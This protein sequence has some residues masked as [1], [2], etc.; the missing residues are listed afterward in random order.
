MAAKQK[1]GLAAAIQAAQGKEGFEGSLPPEFGH[2]IS[3][4]EHSPPPVSAHASIK[5]QN[6]AAHAS[7][8]EDSVTAQAYVSTSQ[9]TAQAIIKN[10]QVTAHAMFNNSRVTA[11][12]SI[13]NNQL[14]ARAYVSDPSDPSGGK[15][16][17][18]KVEKPNRKSSCAQKEKKSAKDV[19]SAIPKDTSLSLDPKALDASVLTS[20]MRA[21][22]SSQP[23][24]NIDNAPSP[25]TPVAPP[26]APMPS[27]RSSPAAR[28]VSTLATASPPA[29][30]T[31]LAPAPTQSHT[32]LPSSPQQISPPPSVSAALPLNMPSAHSSSAQENIPSPGQIIPSITTTPELPQN[33][34]VM[35]S[36]I[37]PSAKWPT[38]T[39]FLAQGVTGTENTPS[40]QTNWFQ[41][42]QLELN[43][44]NNNNKLQVGSNNPSDYP[45][46]KERLMGSFFANTAA[47]V[48]E[49]PRPQTTVGMV[50]RPN[51][52]PATQ[53]GP[54]PPPYPGTTDPQP[55]PTPPSY[56]PKSPNLASVNVTTS[57]TA[58]E[59]ASIMKSAGCNTGSGAIPSFQSTFL[60]KRTPPLPP[61]SSLQSSPVMMR[62]EDPSIPIIYWDEDS[63]KDPSP[64][65]WAGV[66]SP[67]PTDTMFQDITLSE[68]MLANL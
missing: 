66:T 65:H 42:K 4:G 34:D 56:A 17:N 13:V 41:R 7:V 63:E 43:R 1:A 60:S 67:E 24:V 15:S 38:L 54:A 23:E 36:Q 20:Q 49:P 14:Q 18:V 21:A 57:P 12:A 10:N 35:P 16:V 61:I 68:K 55:P 40:A 5:D 53:M 62:G 50:T 51:Q 26:S 25:P 58:M 2:G 29:A 31:C 27:V 8:A 30:T 11:H 33:G 28:M 64:T 47:G 52:R 6:V 45:T 19:G 44:I 37:S 46:I 9:I 48:V 59:I 22:I 3:N 39:E 32:G